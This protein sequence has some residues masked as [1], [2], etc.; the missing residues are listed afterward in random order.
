MYDLGLWTMVI[1]L[2]SPHHIAWFPAGHSS[3]S[4]DP[5]HDLYLRLGVLQRSQVGHVRW[6]SSWPSHPAATNCITI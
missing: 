6:E 2:Q 4:L 5:I 3:G 1:P